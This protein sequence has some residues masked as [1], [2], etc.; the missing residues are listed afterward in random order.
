MG[1]KSLNPSPPCPVV[2]AKILPHPLPITFAE[3][4]KPAQGKAGKDGEKLPSLLIHSM[5]KK[6]KHLIEYIIQVHQNNYLSQQYYAI[7]I[8]RFISLLLI[9][10]QRQRLRLRHL[11]CQCLKKKISFISLPLCSNYYYGNAN[12][13]Y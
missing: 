6:F 11:K 3:Q 1:L 2:Q 5:C 12:L 7:N 8:N 4:G 13:I 9:H 10:Q